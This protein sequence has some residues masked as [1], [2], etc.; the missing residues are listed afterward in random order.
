M[1][2]NSARA[3]A[4]NRILERLSPADTRLIT[5]H[6][7]SVDLPLRRQLETPHKAITDVYF[8]DRGF[9]SVV[10]NGHA[11]SIEV[12]LIGREG[13]TGLAVL[14]GTDRTP[15]ATYIQM[16]GGGQRLS[17]ANLRKLIRHSAT[18]KNT[19]LQYAHAFAVQTAQ[20]A[21]AN[22]RSKVEERLARW[23][24]MAQD[25]VDGD[26][27]TLT[28]EFLSVMLGVHRPGVTRALTLLAENG[29][30]SVDRGQITILNRKGLERSADG[31]YGVAEVEF[32]R[33]FG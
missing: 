20:T 27:L 32:K 13:M 26:Q 5:P 22:G 3:R 12:G 23:L 25:R 15:N 28:H 24:L 33:L 31:A 7:S 18:L 19:M 9:A 30:I 11:R 2:R 6:L 29:L 1:A 21:V 8:L 17:A 4:F 14:M 16:A 10:A